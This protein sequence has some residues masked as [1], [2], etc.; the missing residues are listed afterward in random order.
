MLQR[1][2]EHLSRQHTSTLLY[3]IV[4]RAQERLSL[5]LEVN[6]IGTHSIRISLHN[7]SSHYVLKWHV[8]S[9]MYLT[10]HHI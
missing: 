2:P 5:H 4:Q 6:L 8:D 10:L 1:A 9:I 7:V 3:I